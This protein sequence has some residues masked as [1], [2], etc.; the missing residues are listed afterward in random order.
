MQYTFD[1]R[2][3]SKLTAEQAHHFRVIPLVE[4]EDRLI[5][6]TGQAGN[7]YLPQL[8]LLLGKELKE[9][10]CPSPELERYLH[11]YY[12]LSVNADAMAADSSAKTESAVVRLVEKCL[13]TAAKMGAS[14][15]HLER[16]EEEARIRFRWE[17]QLIEKYAVPPEQYNAIISRLKIMAGLDISERRL[18]QDGRIHFQWNK[19]KLDLRFSS[20][21][22]RFGEKCVL[23][24]LQRKDAQLDLATLGM[25]PAEL[26]AYQKSI[27]SPHGL[28][29]I[30]GPTGSGKTTTLYASLHQLNQANR[31]LLTIE[32]PIEYQLKGVNQVQVKAGIG[33]TFDRA[34]RAFLRQD[35]DVIMVGEIRDQATAQIALRAALTGHLVFSTLHTNSAW[36]AI[37]RLTDM[38]VAPYL[39]A[40]S[41]QMVVAQRLVK[42]LCPSCKELGPELHQSQ[43]IYVPGG[44]KQCHFTGFKG[45]KAVF[46]V[47]PVD[48]Q[49]RDFIRKGKEPGPPFWKARTLPSLGQNLEQLLVAG[50]TS[51]EEFVL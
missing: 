17:G 5:L 22:T 25:G 12:P 45:R 9:T 26:Q 40:A 7:E 10:V 27:R 16:Y 23:R 42:I 51:L 49:L 18:P 21:P 39:L 3:L 24:L 32:D 47:L 8:Q 46:E 37:T 4:E 43:E 29:L 20:M 2:L 35:P 13:K 1:Y 38:G 19:Q 6:L 15:I 44:C 50:E 36:D 31:N 30:T 34:L 11:A 28:I 48:S 41:L 14:D 33:L